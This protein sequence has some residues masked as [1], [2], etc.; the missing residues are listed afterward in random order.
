MFWPAGRLTSA[1][2]AMLMRPVTS[3]LTTNAQ[4]AAP[5]YDLLHGALP[6]GLPYIV[7]AQGWCVPVVPQGCR[8][9]QDGTAVFS[10]GDCVDLRCASTVRPGEGSAPPRLP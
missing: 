4:L 9:E 3:R 1:I 6:P 2:S 5:G 8:R 10:V 7:T